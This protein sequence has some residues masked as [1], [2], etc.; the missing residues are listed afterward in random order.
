MNLSYHIQAVATKWSPT[1][2]LLN[3]QNYSFATSCR[4]KQGFKSI[5]RIH[6]V[7]HRLLGMLQ[8]S[9]F[10]I[11]VRNQTAISDGCWPCFQVIAGIRSQPFSLIL[12]SSFRIFSS[13]K[14]INEETFERICKDTYGL[15]RVH[16]PWANVTPIFHK[17]LDHSVELMTR[18]NEERSMKAFSK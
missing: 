4:K 8:D 7:G 9:A 16:Y 15:I 11:V 6:R 5:F 2:L 14:L 13:Y 12:V 1:S 17:V 10:S 18:Y 3:S